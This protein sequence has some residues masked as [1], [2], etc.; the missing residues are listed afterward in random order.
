MTRVGTSRLKSEHTSVKVDVPDKI[1]YD[2]PS[3]KMHQS[4]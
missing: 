4:V 3:R 1:A 2:E